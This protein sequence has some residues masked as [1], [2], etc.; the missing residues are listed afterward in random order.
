MSKS[1]S[2]VLSKSRILN[3]SVIELLVGTEWVAVSA[4]KNVNINFNRQS[5]ILTATDDKQFAGQRFRDELELTG[6]FLAPRNFF[7]FSEIFDLD[8]SAATYAASANVAAEITRTTYKRA[9]G[10]I[11]E[12]LLENSHRDG[13]TKATVNSVDLVDSSGAV[14]TAGLV[15]GTDYEVGLNNGYTTIRAVAGGAIATATDPTDAYLQ[16]DYDYEALSSVTFKGGEAKIPATK[17][18]RVTEVPS[19]TTSVSEQPTYLVV[20]ITEAIITTGWSFQFPDA[21]GENDPFEMPM[22]IASAKGVTFNVQVV[23]R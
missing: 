18:I 20:D 14:I 15:L 17:Q 19:P 23:A 8:T 12:A 11:Y 3:S 21:A 1:S 16:V 10:G 13:S 5:T 6:N 4:F 7:W 9:E 2:D 22:T